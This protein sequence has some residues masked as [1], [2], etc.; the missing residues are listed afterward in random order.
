M[1][2]QTKSKP[3]GST[4]AE[5]L[6]T[7]LRRLRQKRGVPLR[8]VAAAAE[9]DSTHLSKIELGDR[10]PTESQTKALA[11]FFQTPFEKLES[12]RL[13]ERFWHECGA[14]PAVWLAAS[15]IKEQAAIYTVGKES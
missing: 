12:R 3:Y 6:G 10:L 9:M 15:L 14:S 4:P 11:A 5:T 7:F 1:T 8:V 13:A 2:R